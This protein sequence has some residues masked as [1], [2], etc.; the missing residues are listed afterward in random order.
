MKIVFRNLLTTLRRFKMASTLN[1]VGLSVAFAAFIVIMIQVRYDMSFDKFHSKADRLFRVEISGD[2]ITYQAIMPRPRINLFRSASPQIEHGSFVDEYAFFTSYVSVENNGSPVGFDE[3]VWTVYPEFIEMFDFKM[4][5]G[6]KESFSQPSSVVIPQSLA[7]KFFGKESALGKRI[8]LVADKDSVLSINGVYKD[9]PENSWLQNVIYISRNPD[10]LG[11]YDNWG[12][13]S[14]GLYVQL[15]SADGKEEVEKMMLDA[16]QNAG[17]RPEWNQGVKTVRLVPL[18]DMYFKSGVQWDG[19]PKG[20]RGVSMTLFAIAILI[21]MIA[22]INFVNFSTALTPMRIKSINTQKV[23]GSPVSQL[24]SAMIFEA[25]AI[26]LGAY[27]LSLLWIY[28]IE[29]FELTSYFTASIDIVSNWD[30]VLGS[31]CVSLVVGLAAG[32]YPA[33]YS[34]SFQP[35]L[36]LKGSFGLSPKGRTLRTTLIGFQFVV[37][38]GLIIAALFMQLQNSFLLKKD[39]GMDVSRVAVAKL[40]TNL[41]SA[42]S[43]LLANKLKESPQVEKVGF[44]SGAPLGGYDLVSQYG[45][46]NERGENISFDCMCV[47]P[48][49]PEILG[50]ELI[51]GRGF[52]ESDMQKSG[53]YIFN[54]KAMKKYNMKVGERVGSKEEQSN[55]I[56][57][58]MKDFNYRS[59]RH[60]IG[61]FAY[62]TKSDYPWMRV[63]YVKINGDPYTAVKHIESSIKSIDPTFPVAVEFYDS[64][65]DE[66]Y[67]QERKTIGLIT[68]FSLLAVLI[69][70]VGVFGLVVFE[71][72]YRRKEIGVRKVHGATVLQILAMFNKS[73]LITVAACFVVAAPAAWF[74]VNSWLGNFAYRTPLYWWVFAISLLIVL[75]I[76]LLTVTVQSWRAATDNPVNALR[77]E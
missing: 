18:H 8:V 27:I 39:T 7:A 74:G 26:S 37:S 42:N 49:V 56:V 38:L 10:N 34:T 70:L 58:M 13:S 25:V 2:S 24:R 44:G 73:F 3:K 11:P 28:F 64:I 61:P 75:A 76:T 46:D 31:F 67:K 41:A 1:I 33:F 63:V 50:M 51:E 21:V 20:N 12:N 4:I 72:Q 17:D 43:A 23:L 60:G 30:I 19:T 47:T 66:L 55:F 29:K 71:T 45:R 9:F 69:S 40:N 14:Q 16:D 32:L 65:F 35:A 62:E 22:G 36:V 77:S 5:E 48:E 54:E 57:G 15:F 68:T 59:L 52:I 53:T 6:Q